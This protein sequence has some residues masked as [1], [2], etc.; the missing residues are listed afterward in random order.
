MKLKWNILQHCS[1][2]FVF[3]WLRFISWTATTLYLDEKNAIANPFFFLFSWYLSVQKDGCFRGDHN[4]KVYGMNLLWGRCK[5]K[6]PNLA[7]ASREGLGPILIYSQYCRAACLYFQ[8][9]TSRGRHCIIMIRFQPL[10]HEVE[11][12]APRRISEEEA[13]C[14]ATTTLLTSSHNYIYLI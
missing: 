3:F 10:S 11:S 9:L 14:K 5:N 6:A 7:S 1:L 12:E 2:M 4:V 13:R 8:T